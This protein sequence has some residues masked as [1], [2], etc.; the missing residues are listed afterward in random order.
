MWRDEHCKVKVTCKCLNS[1]WL[2]T[3]ACCIF[4]TTWPSA[5]KA[6]LLRHTVSVPSGTC[7]SVL[8]HRGVWSCDRRVIWHLQAIVSTGNV[9]LLSNSTLQMSDILVNPSMGRLSSRLSLCVM[10]HILE[11][12]L[13]WHDLRMLIQML[14]H[15]HFVWRWREGGGERELNEFGAGN[16]VYS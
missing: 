11:C 4:W 14:Y 8:F 16:S 2:H 9:R 12:L 13:Y 7:C 15:V 1:W 6:L 5:V 3:F 10:L